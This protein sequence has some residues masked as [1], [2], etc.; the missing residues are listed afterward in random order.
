MVLIVHEIIKNDTPIYLALDSDAQKKINK[1]IALFLKYD[2]EVYKIDIGAYN[3]VGEMTKQQFKRQ[4][5]TAVLL[6]SNN[7]LLSRIMR[8]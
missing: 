3:D 7:Y 2:I 4:K 6:D 5:E 8:I 1:L